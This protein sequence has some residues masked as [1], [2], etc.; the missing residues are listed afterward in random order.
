[1]FGASAMGEHALSTWRDTALLIQYQP[2]Y[3]LQLPTNAPFRDAR[4]GIKTV[5]PTTRDAF[6]GRDEV[7]EFPG[8]WWTIELTPIPLTYPESGEW[9]AFLAK[10]RGRGGTFRAPD[11]KRYAPQGNVD[12]S[13]SFTVDSVTDENTIDID[14]FDTNQSNVLLQGDYVEFKDNGE[15]K[16]VVSDTDS[17]GNGIATVTFEPESRTDPATDTSVE[18]KRPKAKFRLDANRVSWSMSDRQVNISFSAR[19]VLT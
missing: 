16:Q 3:P 6:T 14:G 18:I 1:M 9:R 11:P 12:T 8:K 4:F 10:L 7:K 15:M 17:D 2:N 13:N 19:E 5:T